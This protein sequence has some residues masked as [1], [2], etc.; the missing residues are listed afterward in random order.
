MTP[1]QLVARRARMATDRPAILHGEATRLKRYGLVDALP[2][3][4]HRK[5]LKTELRARLAASAPP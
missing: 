2:K 1:A 5:V 4:H 3:I